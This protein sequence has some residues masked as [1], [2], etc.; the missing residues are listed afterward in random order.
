M[1]DGLHWTRH[2]CR[3]LGLAPGD[4]DRAMASLTRGTTFSCTMSPKNEV[5]IVTVAGSSVPWAVGDG[6]A[7]EAGGG[8][9]G[10]LLSQVRRGKG[11]AGPAGPFT[12]RSMPVMVPSPATAS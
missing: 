11:G 2:S 8:P 4:A 9:A 12:S 10:A 1:S 5:W 6:F 7:G 3:V